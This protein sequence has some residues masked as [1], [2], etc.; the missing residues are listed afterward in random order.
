MDGPLSL[1]GVGCFC[2]AMV[3]MLVAR[4]RAIGWEYAVGTW[5]GL[6]V[7]ED[8]CLSVLGRILSLR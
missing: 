2:L 6:W 3:L 1:L 8:V 5:L 7:D 4:G